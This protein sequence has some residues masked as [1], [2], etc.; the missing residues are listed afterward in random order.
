LI[1]VVGCGN[2]QKDRSDPRKEPTDEGPAARRGLSDRAFGQSRGRKQ[3]L[4]H[5]CPGLPGDDGHF[6][7][8]AHQIDDHPSAEQALET[9]HGVDAVPVGL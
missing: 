1:D 6:E 2:G 8:I 9:L 7:Q 4:C 3:G 5:Y